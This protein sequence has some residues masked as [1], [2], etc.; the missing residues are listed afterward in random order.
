MICNMY[1]CSVVIVYLD[2]TFSGQ[3]KGSLYFISLKL[4]K[5]SRFKQL[6]MANEVV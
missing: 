1:S 6:I 5:T 4:C 2:Y 3:R